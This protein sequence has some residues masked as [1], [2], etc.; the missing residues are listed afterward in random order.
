MNNCIFCGAPLDDDALFCTNCGKKVET[1]GKKCPKCG[2][3]VLGDSVFCAKCGTKLDEQVVTQI[4]SPQIVTPVNPPQENEEI[5]Y[6][7]E[8]DEKTRKWKTILW[9]F[10]LVVILALVGYYIYMN[11]NKNGSNS[12][13]KTEREPIA[14]KGSINEKIGFSMKLHFNGNEVEGTEHYDNQKAADTISIKGTIDENSYL[15]LHEYDKAIECGKFEGFLHE[16]SYSGTFTNS[17]GKTMS[18]SANVMSERD[19]AKEKEAINEINKKGTIIAN[20]DGKIYY[21]DKG[22]PQYEYD[23]NGDNCGKLYIYN[24]ADGITSYVIIWSID[25]GGIYAI[26]N[27]KYIDMKITFVMYNTSR[28]GAGIGNFCTDVR[29][30]NIKTG[31]WKTI[32]EECTKAVFV[33]NNR[34]I[35]ITTANITNYDEAECAVDY[36]YEFSDTI[37]DL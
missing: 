31:K 14:L 17:Q 20:V 30:Y 5:I 11:Y 18:F 6:D 15:T 29:Q 2:T 4:D 26:E 10:V 34:K 27:C 3:D 8:K 24:I 35:K 12:T 21:L 28:K 22:K 33:D 23:E 7:W 37:I 19:L 1:Q 16:N 9:S 32:A 25:D 13:I 36:E